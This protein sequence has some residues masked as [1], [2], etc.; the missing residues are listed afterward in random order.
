MPLIYI[1]VDVL[2]TVVEVTALSCNMP[3]LIVLVRPWGNGVLQGFSPPL[4]FIST[5]Y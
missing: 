2:H 3:A 1:P 5:Y 4:T